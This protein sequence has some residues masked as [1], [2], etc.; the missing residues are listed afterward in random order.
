MYEASKVSKRSLRQLFMNHYQRKNLL[1]HKYGHSE[2]E[3]KAAKYQTNKVRSQRAMSRM[4][5]LTFGPLI[6]LEEM[7]ESA[8]RKVKRRMNKE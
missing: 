3:V 6:W 7:R 1:V 5:Q 2:D 4:M 8:V